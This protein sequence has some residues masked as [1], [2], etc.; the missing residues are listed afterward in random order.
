[1][2]GPGGANLFP[3]SDLKA[4]PGPAPICMYKYIR[5]NFQE[6][7]RIVKLV[8]T[9]A[10]TNVA[11]MFAL[12]PEVLTMIEVVIMGGCLGVGNT[13]PVMEFNIQ[14]DPEAAKLV[15]ESGVPLCMVPL[16]VTHTVLATTS[17]LDRIG[18]GTPFK[19]TI[20]DLLTFFAKTYKE[21]FDFDHP[22]VHDPCAVAY[23]LAPQAF[24][25]VR[26]LRVDIETSSILTAGQTV[27]DVWN[28]S[29]KAPNCDVCIEMDHE[30]FWDVM[31][32]AISAADDRVQ[33]AMKNV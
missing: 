20:R 2:D 18:F 23:L 24:T 10:L 32:A 25:K 6:N 30:K 7:G 15:F 27:V 9:G 31:I 14:T 3:P 4:C 28:Q 33:L 29:G 8:A 19:A 11:L 5:E 16:E 1:M 17:I 13:G 22:P 26:R 12:Y 21:V